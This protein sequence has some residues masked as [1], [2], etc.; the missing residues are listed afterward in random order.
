MATV[1]SLYRFLSQDR[2]QIIVRF[3][4]YPFLSAWNSQNHSQHSF[5]AVGTIQSEWGEGMKSPC[6]SCSSSLVKPYAIDHLL[7]SQ[8]KSN[9]GNF[10]SFSL[11]FFKCLPLSLLCSI[12]VTSSLLSP[13]D[14]INY[15]LFYASITLKKNLS[16]SFF[17]MMYYDFVFGYWPS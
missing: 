14:L 2:P 1:L 11:F 10:T 13:Q 7:L 9:V 5:W 16:G 4:Y 8:I 3:Q 6:S 17:V 15:S 12:K